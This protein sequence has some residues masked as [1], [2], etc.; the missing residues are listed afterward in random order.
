MAP[1]S[2]N[3]RRSAAPSFAC[4]SQLESGTVANAQP[5]RVLLT[6]DHQIVREG[7]RFTLKAY[8]F[9]QVVGEAATGRES[10]RKATE[11]KPDVVLMDI[12][13]PEMDGLAATAEMRRTLPHVKIIALT[14]HDSREYVLE[15]L[16]SGAQGYVLKDTSPDELVRAIR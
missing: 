5:I 4:A 7:I 3:Q 6:D 8:P 1:V 12:N 16:R 10:I 15:I 14:V 2:S 13:M 11:L 9:L